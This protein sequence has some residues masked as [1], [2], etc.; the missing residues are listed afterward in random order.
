MRQRLMIIFTVIAMAL[1]TVASWS[2]ASSSQAASC[3]QGSGSAKTDPD[4]HS[5]TTWW[6]CGNKV[7]ATLYRDSNTG[8]V[9]GTMD[10]GISWFVCYKRGSLHDGGNNVW[11]YTQGDTPASGAESRKAWGYMPALNVLTSTDPWPGM[12]E[13][14]KPATPAKPARTNGPNKTVLFVHG[15][16]G[17]G[18]VNCSTYWGNGEALSLFRSRGWSSIVNLTYYAKG[19]SGC[20]RF[21]S[22]GVGTRI[23]RTGFDL[24][25]YIYNNYSS[26]GKAVDIVAHSMGGVVTRVAIAGTSNRRTVSG[27]S[28]P[29]YLY[30]EDVATL[31]S[32]HEGA[33]GITQLCAEVGVA[34]CEDMQPGS[35]FM[36]S[37]IIPDL[38]AT[39]RVGYD[40]PQ[41]QMGTDWSAVGSED[42]I[43]VYPSSGLSLNA[44]YHFGHKYYYIGQGLT[45][46]QMANIGLN[47]GKLYTVKYCDYTSSCSMKSWSN[48]NYSKSYDGPLWVAA[49]ATEQQSW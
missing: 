14:P 46:G 12:A 26:K 19:G 47:G 32:P 6:T 41:S 18:S 30:I 35:P 31:S 42:D 34:E 29:P 45:H 3:T 16:N 24:A 49:L 38:P 11:Y 22:S 43:I 17:G 36:K 44:S 21:S 28:F 33:G 23:S 20:T 40:N 10:T 8:S 7:G 27:M 2:L 5:W 37:W 1:T 25:W 9:T 39:N 48:W 15:F 13:C 4:G